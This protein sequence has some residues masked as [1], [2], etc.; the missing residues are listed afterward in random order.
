MHSLR[1][2]IGIKGS[3]QAAGGTMQNKILVLCG[4]ILFAS[5]ACD[6]SSTTS[7]SAAGGRGAMG[8][9]GNTVAGSTGGSIAMTSIFHP[10]A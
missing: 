1:K 4:A 2:S 3:G 9:G 10:T 6:S 5:L 7:D 8:T